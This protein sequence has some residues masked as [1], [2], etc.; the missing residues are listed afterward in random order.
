LTQAQP[1]RV[2]LL[3]VLSYLEALVI[4]QRNCDPIAKRIQKIVFRLVALIAN[5]KIF[6]LLNKVIPG[7]AFVD[8][9][10]VKRVICVL[11]IP[12]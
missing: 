2:G 11:D 5:P 12:R 10:L 3:E 7:L 8:S 6:D 9:G 1:D 4:S